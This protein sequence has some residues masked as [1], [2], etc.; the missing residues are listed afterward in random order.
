MPDV[1]YP[2]ALLNFH[3]YQQWLIEAKIDHGIQY[4][5]AMN[6]GAQIKTENVLP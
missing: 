1:L 4:L 6:L 2:A 5:G 3:Y